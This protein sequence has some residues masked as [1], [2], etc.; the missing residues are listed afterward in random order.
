[1]LNEPQKNYG[2][3][4]RDILVELVDAVRVCGQENMIEMLLYIEQK[5]LQQNNRLENMGQFN[6]TIKQN[7]PENI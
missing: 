2:V 4:L 1:L 5:Q 3:A 6:K 7:L